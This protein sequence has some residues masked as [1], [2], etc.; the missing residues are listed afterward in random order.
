MK[1]TALKSDFILLVVAAIWGLAFV[2]QR[3]GMDHVGPFTFNGVRF[4]LGG[5]SLVPFVFFPRNRI[6]DQCAGGL[7][8]SGI[9]SGLILFCGISLQQVGLVYTTAGKAGFITGLYV[10]MVPLIGL[11]IKNSRTSPG[12]W[13]GA[14]LAG[15]GMYFLSVTKDMDMAFGDLLVFFSAICF[16]FHLIIIGRL[17][18]RFDTV[19]LSLVQCFVCAA[20]SLV[21]ALFCET[22]VLADI[23]DVA[24]PLLYGGVMSVG[25]A[26]SL[27]IYGQKN[28]PTS[29][30][31]IILCMES[32]VA[33]LGGWIIL[34][35]I[36]SKRGVFGCI[37]M[38]AGM[39]I[40][41]LYP[42]KRDPDAD[43]GYKER[44]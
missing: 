25:V 13:T 8:P 28:S 5:L 31:A 37:L 4:V 32:V 40:S 3:I 18:Q 35:E 41:Q 12:T 21:T 6:K 22:M 36:L 7:I 38:L 29:H 24:M 19:G 42:T 15:I 33:A 16:A 43:P 9:I 30:A 34:G 1:S 39:L 14:A 20:L 23:L 27:Q 17:S 26:Y 2:A 11:F 10:V 44:H